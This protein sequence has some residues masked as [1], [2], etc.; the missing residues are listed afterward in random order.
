MKLNE[1]FLLN[2]DWQLDTEINVFHRRKCDVL[3]MREAL[4]LFGTGE[5]LV[6]SQSEVWI[7]IRL[8]CGK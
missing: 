8:D 2:N 3:P 1:L 4:R 7:Y 6:F 5:V